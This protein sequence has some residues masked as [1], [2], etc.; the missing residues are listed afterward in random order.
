VGVRRRVDLVATAYADELS[1]R[2]LAEITT[3]TA[4]QN[5]RIIGGQMARRP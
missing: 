4:D 1:L 3:I 5:V 2:A